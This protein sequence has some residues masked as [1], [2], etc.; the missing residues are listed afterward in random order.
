ML[1]RR[2]C[3]GRKELFLVRQHTPG[4]QRNNFVW[5]TLRFRRRG[6]LVTQLVNI[7]NHNPHT[8]TPLTHTD[9]QIHTRV[10]HKNIQAATFICCSSPSLNQAE[11]WIW[12][13]QA[14]RSWNKSYFVFLVIS[15][16][17]QKYHV[18]NWRSLLQ[19]TRSSVV[20]CWLFHT[21]LQSQ[22]KFS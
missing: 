22:D 8:Q 2:R 17:Y 14:N 21:R 15:T 6:H 3:P 1:C 18:F 9:I 10:Q 4:W 20:I 16:K 11:N 19:N 7:A 12:F 5:S 13:H